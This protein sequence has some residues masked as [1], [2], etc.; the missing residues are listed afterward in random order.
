MVTQSCPQVLPLLKRW[1]ESVFYYSLNV[2]TGIQS[3]EPIIRFF[4]HQ[5]LLTFRLKKDGLNCMTVAEYFA[6]APV[7]KYSHCTWAA[8][9]YHVSQ[10][11]DLKQQNS[12]RLAAFLAFINPSIE[13]N[14]LFKFCRATKWQGYSG[15]KRGS[16]GFYNEAMKS[17]FTA[18]NQHIVSECH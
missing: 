13:T 16:H 6:C 11:S 9:A 17:L 15:E 10:W 3:S 7:Q 5:S 2:D 18:L 4:F 12:N 1:A 8:T 14:W